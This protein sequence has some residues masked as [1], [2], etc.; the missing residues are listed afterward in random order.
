MAVDFLQEYLRQV[1][2][3]LVSATTNIVSDV[4]RVIPGLIG[5]AV[6]LTVGVFIGKYVKKFVTGVIQSTKADDW[7][8]EK[9]LHDA[10][11]NRELSSIFGSFAKW[12]VIVIFLAQSLD[13]IQMR[14][15][16]SFTEFLISFINSLIAAMIIL[17]GG[18][19]LARYVRNVV[20]S[21][22]YQYKKTIAVVI[23]V[24]II[25][26]SAVISLQTVGINTK[27][28]TD[29]FIVGFSA[30]VFGLAIL[31]GLVF[32]LAFRKD[33]VQLANDLRKEVGK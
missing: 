8:R 23:E 18:L 21:T 27:I 13:L 32:V 28:L 12:Y 11:G 16:R 22:E 14:V 25:Y 26:V 17:V 2:A 5:A 6:L 31:A 30:M 15:L 19:L 29:A 10:L 3:N 33:I 9:K 20:E 7:L 4:I 24:M 1:G